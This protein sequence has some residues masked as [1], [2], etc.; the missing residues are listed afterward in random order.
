MPLGSP[1]LS[2]NDIY[3]LETELEVNPILSIDREKYRL[4]YLMFDLVNGAFQRSSSIDWRFSSHGRLLESG[5][6]SNLATLRHFL[7][8]ATLDKSVKLQGIPGKDEPATLPRVSEL[9]VLSRDSPWTTTIRNEKG[10]TVGDVWIGI[11]KDYY[12]HNLADHEYNSLAARASEILRR[13]SLLH[14]RSENLVHDHETVSHSATHLQGWTIDDWTIVDRFRRIGA[15]FSLSLWLMLD[16]HG[17]L[18]I[19]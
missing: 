3:L 6:H 16:L 1:V 10:V 19:A 4:A 14:E 2:E 5:S 9:V 15:S 18:Q 12:E 17:D 11:F 8:G 13:T 7:S